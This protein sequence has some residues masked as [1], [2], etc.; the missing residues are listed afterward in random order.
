M[1]GEK[2]LAL[3]NRRWQ[4]DEIKTEAADQGLFFCFRRGSETLLFDPGQNKAVNRVFR[5]RF[6][7]DRRQRRATGSDVCPVLSACGLILEARGFSRC[8]F[9]PVSAFVDPFA[10]QIN[11][12]RLQ[13]LAAHRHTRFATE[14]EDAV[15]QSALSTVAGNDDLH[16][17]RFVNQPQLG[18]DPPGAVAL[19]TVCLEDRLNV[20]DEVN[21]LLHPVES[22]RSLYC[23]YDH[24][25]SKH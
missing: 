4:T 25:G 20:A 13:R 3:C 9:R 16:R 15:H 12:F 14:A 17:Q 18:L 19:I 5:P 8:R 21:L 2:L 6:V 23:R 1:V 7:L 22:G 24:A 10:N 11:L